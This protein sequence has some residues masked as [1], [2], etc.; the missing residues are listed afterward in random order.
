MPHVYM[1]RCADGSYYVGSTRDLDQRMAQHWSGKGAK[2]TSTRLPVEL[3]WAEEY[4]SVADAYAMEKK[5]Q[6]WSRA[7]REALIRG[8]WDGV[9]RNTGNRRQLRRKRGSG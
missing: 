7:K 1:L 8:D 4:D 2:Y 5:I 6:G 9:H 3:V